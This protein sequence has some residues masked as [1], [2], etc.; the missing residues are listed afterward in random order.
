MNEQ[1]KNALK[2]LAEIWQLSPDIRLGQLFAHLGLLGEIHHNR[3]LGYIDDDELTSVLETHLRELQARLE[4]PSLP[5]RR[6][7]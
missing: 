6:T 3:T 1:Q 2:L 4:E 5:A 7:A